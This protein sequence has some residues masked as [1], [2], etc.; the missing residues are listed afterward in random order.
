MNLRNIFLVAFL[1]CGLS[2]KASTSPLFQYAGEYHGVLVA[3][4]RALPNGKNIRR[5]I[6]ITSA[7]FKAAPHKVQGGLELIHGNIRE[8]LSFRNSAFEYKR[9]QNGATV[10]LDGTA[11]I[12]RFSISYSATAPDGTATAGF[13][14]YF[15]GGLKVIVTYRTSAR[16]ETL[17]YFLYRNAE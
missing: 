10:T 16:L 11:R 7:E 14:E 15:S 13:L 6:P 9:T 12:R 5:T 1:F 17:T 4:T 8:H 2:A 3:V